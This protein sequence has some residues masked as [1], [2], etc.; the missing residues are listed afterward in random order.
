MFTQRYDKAMRLPDK[1]KNRDRILRIADQKQ[2]GDE[3]P[4]SGSYI[5]CQDG[6]LIPIEDPDLLEI[7]TRTNATG[8]M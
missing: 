8:R 6:S 2:A 3:K 7:I 5:I 4:S 1:L